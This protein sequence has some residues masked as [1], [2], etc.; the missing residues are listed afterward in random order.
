MTARNL[1]WNTGAAPSAGDFLKVKNAATGEVEAGTPAGG[2]AALVSGKGTLTGYAVGA[3]AA[4]HA[5]GFI[6]CWEWTPNTG[7]I[8][9]NVSGSSYTFTVDSTDPADGSFWIDSTSLSGAVDLANAL[10]ASV[11]AILSG[12]LQNIT[13][14]GT[15]VNFETVGDGSGATISISST[16]VGLSVG[17]TNGADA[18]AAYGGTQNLDIIAANGSKILKP[19]RIW[20]YSEDQTGAYFSGCILNVQLRVGATSY[21]LG[22]IPGSA[23]NGSELMPFNTAIAVSQEWFAGRASAKLVAFLSTEEGY[24]FPTG[25]QVTIY[26]KAEQS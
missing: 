8:T 9:I 12:I 14:D 18:I 17:N 25:G 11:S 5:T 19:L 26:A 10:F 6:A 24:S 16:L 1:F 2:G 13:L 4:T 20:V 7:T 3:V 23:F 21:A 22:T 15:T